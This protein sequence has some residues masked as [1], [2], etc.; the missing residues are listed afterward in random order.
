MSAW[1]RESGELPAP[2][3][4]PSGRKA[5]RGLFVSFAVVSGHGVW[6]LRPA[7]SRNNGREARFA[8]CQNHTFRGRFFA[9]PG[10]EVRWGCLLLILILLLIIIRFHPWKED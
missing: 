9:T 4:P 2:N 3:L 5:G 6:G 8:G 1:E 7:I 10:G